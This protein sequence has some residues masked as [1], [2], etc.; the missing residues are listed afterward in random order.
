VNVH[1]NQP[2]DQEEAPS[3]AGC[4]GFPRD[5]VKRP[6]ACGCGQGPRLCYTE[7]N[8]WIGSEVNLIS[9]S[10]VP[11]VELFLCKKIAPLATGR[12]LY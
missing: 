2:E 12:R 9:S 6:C 4:T 3:S 5:G 1:T 11:P 10:T 7:I 8:N